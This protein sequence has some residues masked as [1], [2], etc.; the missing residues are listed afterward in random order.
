[1]YQAKNA[2]VAITALELLRQKGWTI[3]D[4]N[5]KDALLTVRWPARFELLRR[6]PVFVADGGH[7]PQGISAVAESLMEHFPNRKITFLIG[8]M[9]DKDIPQMIDVLAPLAKEFITVTPNNPRALHA[10]VLAAM[11]T[12]RGFEAISRDDVPEGVRVAIERA[13]S[14]GIVCALGS[15]YMLGDV[16]AALGVK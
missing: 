10:D 8:V 13:G 12:E 9:A 15:L 1:T 3:S 11:L 4:Q 5:L 16:R 6:N 2:A 7:N 14:D